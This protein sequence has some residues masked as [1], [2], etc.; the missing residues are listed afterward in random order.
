MPQEI[1][2]RAV[3]KVILVAAG[4]IAALYLV[5]LVRQVVFLFL[6]SVFLAV[7]LGPAV[8]A[9]HRSRVPRWAAILAVY[10]GILLSL[11]GIGL[12]VVPP[13]VNG[14]NK[15][16]DNLP[17]YVTDL[18]K[19]KTVRRYDDKY[20]VVD[21]L[22]KEARKLPKR[23]GD[24]VGTLRDVTVGV[25]TR[26]TQFFTVLVMTFLLL[27]DGG[28]FMEFF[29]RQL[30]PR[31]QTRARRLA[32]DMQRAVTGYVSGNLIISL[33]AGSV[34]FV[35]LK[36]LN[37]PFAVPL[38]VVM[39]F[40][41]LIPLIGATIGGVILG[42]VCAIADFPTALIVWGVV[43]IV[44]QQI[45]NNLIQPIVY[46][47]TVQI[48]ALAVIVAILIGGELLGVLGVLIAIPV[49]AMVQIAIKDWWQFRQEARAGGLAAEQLPG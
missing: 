32:S 20:Q 21:N 18:R 38:A 43:F 8:N 33:I 48:H 11:V 35:T 34:A 17:G 29:Y 13:V 40:F 27:L 9:L 25:F 22:E 16:V 42:I 1:S 24:A 7:A 6:I 46:R 4:V 26:A 23:V 2:S 12:A 37:V 14:V 45:E 28:R 49:A 15:L 47:R 39:A 41:D 44:Y 30:S 3:A 31:T 5:Y 36:A 19:N 10:F